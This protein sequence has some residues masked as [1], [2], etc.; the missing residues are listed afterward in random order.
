MKFQVLLVLIIRTTLNIPHI[1]SVLNKIPA[2]LDRTEYGIERQSFLL[3][4]FFV[5]LFFRSTFK[6][7]VSDKVAHE[8][9]PS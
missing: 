5:V 4:N 8:K 3:S 7:L 1:L 6:H 9:N 2:R